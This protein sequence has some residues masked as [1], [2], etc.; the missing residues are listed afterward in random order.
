MKVYN[1]KAWND[2]REIFDI[3]CTSNQKK[4]Y[5][6]MMDLNMVDEAVKFMIAVVHRALEREHR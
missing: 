1:E 3:H 6:A 5:L 2:L 4:A